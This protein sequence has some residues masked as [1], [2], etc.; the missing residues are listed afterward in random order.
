MKNVMW[1][2]RD[3]RIEDNTALKHALDNSEKL[4]LLFIVN[5]KQLLDKNANNQQAFFHSV[6]TFKDMLEKKG[7]TLNILYGSIEESFQRLKDTYPDLSEVYFNL[8]ESGFGAG[9]DQ[10]AVNVFN[11]LNININSF[12]DHYLHNADEIKTDND[13]YYKVYSAYFKKWEKA[14]KSEVVAV[15]FNL[16]KIVNEAK[17][18]KDKEEFFDLLLDNDFTK[19]L[20]LGSS[21]AKQRLNDFVKNHLST[22]D[23]NRDLPILS[24]TSKL[25]QYL[26]TGE[27]SIRTVYHKVNMEKDSKGKETFIRELAWRDFYNMVYTTNP[28]AKEMPLR[29]EFSNIEWENDM[30]KF[31]AWKKGK[32]GFP[33]VDAGMRQLLQT[34]FMHNRLRMIT[35]SFLVKD[36][37]IDWRLGEKFFQ[38][39]L[40]DYDAASNIGGWQWVA[41]TGSDSAPYFR[42]FNPTTQSERFDKDGDFIRKYVLELRGVIGKKIHD[43]SA[44]TLLQQ[45]EFGVIINKDYP[46]PI[47]DHKIQRLKV[48]AAYEESKNKHLNNY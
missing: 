27:I 9:R 8:D 13:T 42:I 4:I 14:N 17:F 46:A 24:A 33:I 12:H 6:K 28:N 18:K 1:F 35:A 2:R 36:L 41:S 45:Q 25:S 38:E 37:L 26:R 15:D 21:Q 19:N 10:E 47:V 48:I 44:L 31:K 3:L 30:D 39:N 16:D 43:P 7:A 34:G 20:N 29:D 23:K 32:T 5:P 40:I 22:Y 11:D